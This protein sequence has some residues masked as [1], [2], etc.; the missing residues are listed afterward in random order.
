MSAKKMNHL[1]V[2]TDFFALKKKF[3]SLLNYIQAIFPV[4]LSLAVSIKQITK[5]DH[6][7]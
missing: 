6:H 2:L 3:S 5:K 4:L 7:H 1:G